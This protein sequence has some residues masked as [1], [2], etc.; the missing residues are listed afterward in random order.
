MTPSRQ[1]VW[2]RTITVEDLLAHA[3]REHR[4]FIRA[5]MEDYFMRGV[6]L[7]EGY[8]AARRDTLGPASPAPP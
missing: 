6:P 2:A 1:W 4:R 8:A 5:A 7:I 3:A